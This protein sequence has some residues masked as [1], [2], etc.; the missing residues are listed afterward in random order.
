MSTGA[1][2]SIINSV[3][4]AAFDTN[5]GTKLTDFLQKFGSSEGKF[6]NTID[7]LATFETSFKFY[8]CPSAELAAKSS[9]ILSRVGNAL[10]T[11]VT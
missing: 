11:A 8:P 1:L 6:V 10:G 5:S 4:D 9:G 3:V 7:P 2:G